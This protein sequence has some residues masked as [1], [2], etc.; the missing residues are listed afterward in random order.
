MCC[1]CQHAQRLIH[2]LLQFLIRYDG[3]KEEWI[4]TSHIFEPSKP[5]IQALRGK[6]FESSFCVLLSPIPD[7]D[8]ITEA[9]IVDFSSAQAMETDAGDKTVLDSK[10]SI[11]KIKVELTSDGATMWIDVNRCLSIHAI[12][13]TESELQLRRESLL[14]ACKRPTKRSKSSLDSPRTPHARNDTGDAEEGSAGPSRAQDGPRAAAKRQVGKVGK[15]RN[16]EREDLSLSQQVALRS[17]FFPSCSASGKPGFQQDAPR[18]SRSGSSHLPLDSSL[19]LRISPRSPLRGYAHET[20]VRRLLHNTPTL[21]AP[22]ACHPDDCTTDQAGGVRGGRPQPDQHS[23]P[24][25]PGRLDL[26]PAPA[27]R[28][29]PSGTRGDHLG[30]KMRVPAG[31]PAT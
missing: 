19:T 20:R 26:E 30:R 18:G 16:V 2:F 29:R 14:K 24:V 5:D 17:Q 1:A 10:A 3:S 9:R 6:Q 7:D 31:R 4:A 27:R 8:S 12:Q 25:G 23:H 11:D 15:K 28:D 22:G 13:A 21:G